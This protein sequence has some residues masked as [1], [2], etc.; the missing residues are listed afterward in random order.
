MSGGSDIIRFEE[1]DGVHS[2]AELGSHMSQA[3]ANTVITLDATHTL[4]L[5]N[6]SMSALSAADFVF[7]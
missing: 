1:I 2:F 7:C 3:G 6:V 5:D 4:T